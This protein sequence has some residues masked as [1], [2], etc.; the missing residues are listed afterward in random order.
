MDGRMDRWTDGPMGRWADGQDIAIY[1]ADEFCKICSSSFFRRFG[2]TSGVRSTRVNRD[3]GF[4][5]EKAELEPE[6]SLA[7]KMNSWQS[8]QKPNADW[9]GKTRIQP[10]NTNGGSITVL[11]TS[12]LTVLDWSVLLIKKNCQLSYS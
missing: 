8:M 7:L 11:L 3:S 2:K 12:C 6:V 1:Q 9:K 4:R 10:G 5:F